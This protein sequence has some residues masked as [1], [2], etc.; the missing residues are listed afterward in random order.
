MK[1]KR[2]IIAWILILAV[3]V[4][5]LIPGMES[6]YQGAA[7][8]YTNAKYTNAKDFFNSTGLQG[9]GNHVEVKDGTI[10]FA[11]K[12]KLAY[13]PY[14]ASYKTTYRTVGYDVTLTGGGATVSFAVKKGTSLKEIQSA[15]VNEYEQG[16]WYQYCLLCVDRE[17][18]IQLATSVDPDGAK[19][20]LGAESFKV[21]LDAI[22]VRNYAGMSGSIEEDGYGDLNIYN[23]NNNYTWVWRLKNP[24]Q[25]QEA[26]NL[27]SGNKT[28]ES[29]TNITATFK[30]NKLDVYYAVDGLPEI[31][32]NSSS[33]VTVASGY[34]T[35]D[36]TLNGVKIPFILGKNNV[37]YKN[38]ARLAEDIILLNPLT[39]G[40][41]ISKTG[42]HLDGDAAGKEWITATGKTF[43]AGGVYA[44]ADIEPATSGKSQAICLYANWKPNEYT[45]EYNANGG[46]G[47]MSSSKHT[48]DKS[49]KLTENNFSKEGYNFIGWSTTPNGAVEYTDGQN[50]L[51]ETTENGKVIKLYAVWQKKIFEIT[52]ND[53]GATS[54]GSSVM[55]EAYEKG[56]YSDK[57]ATSAITNV[58]KP[59][60]TGYTFGGYFDAKNGG[61]AGHIDA[62]GKI[63]AA[64]TAFL[65]DRTIYAKWIAN[66][67]TIRYNGVDGTLA[68]TAATY[69]K[70]VVLR[71]N[72]SA[73]RG[74]TFTGWA[75]TEGGAVVYADKET[76]KNITS[77][78]G[79]VIDLYAVWE[80]VTA[81]ITLDPQEG[82]GGTG[83]FYEKFGVNFYTNNV[84]VEI[85]DKINAPIRIGYDFKGYFGDIFGSGSALIGADGIFGID[86][87]YFVQDSTLFAKWLAKTYTLTL[88]KEGGTGGTSSVTVTYDKLVP[89]AEADVVPRIQSPTRYGFE[90]KGYYTE[91]NGNGTKFYNEFMYS[92]IVYK[93]T[94]D[95]PLFSYWVDNYAPAVS[96]SGNDKWTHDQTTIEA[97]ASDYGMGLKSL[98]I[99][100]IGE[101]GSLTAVATADNLNGAQEKKL[102]FTNTT[103]GAVRYKAVAVDMNGNTSESYSTVYYDFV[104]PTGSLVQFTQNGNQ[105]TI[106]VDVT[107]ANTSN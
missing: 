93:S 72:I 29:V 58:T 17:K 46:T 10:Y 71:P 68:D 24:K 70:E 78:N 79:A 7:A 86:S 11:N 80:P 73:K 12:L 13:A 94:Q 92:D 35:G 89:G 84:F 77:V 74:Y 4:T 82:S 34:L 2:K 5:T 1:G 75:R 54:P 41:A 105:F 76:V 43:K 88:N 85:L 42:Y 19:K 102:T 62:T 32:T 101:D 61:G 23:P 25:L 39:G 67:Y 90:F 53:D 60:K 59:V 27:Y 45:F 66:T 69:D 31:S 106:I 44:P 18:V 30:N 95:T 63:T 52:L 103:Q 50:I 83:Y 48:Y 26:D 56:F 40:P 21:C 3:L 64:S 36:Y 87:T 38:S 81:Q 14:A 98:I 28:F 20:L 49:G 107:D 55:Y 96:L 51:N 22:I 9:D 57:N 100:R 91:K 6:N 99:Y 104:K 33:K 15:T 37:L 8:S 16:V 47:T 97:S 65:Q